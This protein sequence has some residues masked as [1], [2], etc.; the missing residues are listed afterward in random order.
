MPVGTLGGVSLAGRSFRAATA[1]VTTAALALLVGCAPV[2]TRSSQQG[3]AGDRPQVTKLLVFVVENHSLQQMRQGMPW[4]NHLAE[5][6]AYATRY[7]AI[8][9][10]SLPNYLA[11]AGG[12]TF[13]VTDDGPPSAHEIASASVFGS[14][15]RAGRTATT[16]A[17]GMA[18]P[19]QRLDAGRY[20]VRHN[21]WTYFRSERRDCLRHDVPLRR[22]GH[23]V[24]AGDL[25]RVGMVV[26]DACN[27]AHD[28]SL[29]RAD[30][31]LRRQVGT[32]LRGPDFASGHLA[33]VVTADED[34]R[35]H[36]NTV[37]T[38]VAHP[39]LHHEVV[40]RALTHYA[41]SRAYAEAASIEP[42]G[43]ASRAR[44]L[45]AAFGLR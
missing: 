9:H 38:V 30:S 23:D 45:L 12:G 27:D 29:A 21:P 22:L 34:D 10:P 16:Y 17:E 11:I 26:P 5:R 2:G 6:Y 4:L 31:W 36:D 15:L 1:V 28:C 43:R 19:C 25:P 24:S 33:V 7:R 42:L 32:V 18:S 3:V 39:L 41:L 37:L 13:G 14:A 20:L 8:T 35:H 40:R 44:S